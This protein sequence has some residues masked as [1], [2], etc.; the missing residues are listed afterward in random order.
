MLP[1]SP[2]PLLCLGRFLLPSVDVATPD[3]LDLLPLPSRDSSSFLPACPIPLSRPP[4]TLTS[5]LT[6]RASSSSLLSP[7]LIDF[8][9]LEGEWPSFPGR[10]IVSA[11]ES[12]FTPASSGGG[13]KSIATSC[14]SAGGDDLTTVGAVF[15][16]PCTDSSSPTRQCSEAG[17]FLAPMSTSSCE[18]I[19]SSLGVAVSCTPS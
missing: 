11:S 16:L 19:A 5:I 13:S 9:I 4:P 7:C 18:S 15:S 10:T 14:K 1:I 3:S 6:L 17:L 8:R 12:L 2:F